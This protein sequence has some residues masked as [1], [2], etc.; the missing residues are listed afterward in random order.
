MGDAG[1][2]PAWTAFGKRVFYSVYD[3]KPLISTNGG[4][5][6]FA[7]E[8]GNGWWTPAALKFW[9]H[10]DFHAGLEAKGVSGCGDG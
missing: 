1:L 8:L 2:E 9:G 3:A 6:V 5:H 10:L 7:A 4:P